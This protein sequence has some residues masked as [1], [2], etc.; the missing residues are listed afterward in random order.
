MK[1]H[2]T[3]TLKDF[4]I[5][6]VIAYFVTLIIFCIF[7][8]RVIPGCSLLQS[9]LVL[10]LLT[11]LS[12]GLIY[13]EKDD[14]RNYLSIATNVLIPFGIY[15]TLA[16][17]LLLPIP[18]GIVWVLLIGLDLVYV[19]FYFYKVKR[20]NYNSLLE[21]SQLVIGLASLLSL[22][23]VLSFTLFGSSII[24]SSTKEV[25]AYG[26]RQIFST[27]LNAGT[28]LLIGFLM[29]M[30]IEAILFTV[31]YIPVRVYAG[32]YH[33]STPQR[34]WAFSAIMLWIA[35]CIVKYTPQMYFW[36]ITTLS[37][38]ACIVVF[39]LSPVEDRN[40]RLDEKEHHVY[41]IRAIVVMTIEAVAAILLFVFHF[42]QFVLVLEIAWCSLAVMLLLGKGKNVF[43]NKKGGCA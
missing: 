34:C 42:K 21:K 33:A 36:V 7:I 38:I 20:R 4:I 23:I 11:V 29:Q 9:K 28:M 22:V 8:F 5:R 24:Q 12:F 10:F 15:T 17:M 13:F 14:R 26:L 1:Q 31:I 18:L 25:C 41:H 43:E 27:I 39:L 35:L 30:L 3:F 6:A 37:L 40:K 16:Y 19:G 2:N 32:G